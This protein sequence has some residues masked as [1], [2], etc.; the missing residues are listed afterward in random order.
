M[1]QHPPK[2]EHKQKNTNRYGLPDSSV[3][4]LNPSKGDYYCPTCGQWWFSEYTIEWALYQYFSLAGYIPKHGNQRKCEGNI[5]VTHPLNKEEW[6]IEAKGLTPAKNDNISF[7]I[8]L[9]QILQARYKH[10]PNIFYALA[11]P[12]CEPFT[13][14]ANQIDG[15]DRE[16]LHLHWIWVEQF[17]DEN[18]VTHFNVTINCPPGSTCEC[19]KR[20]KSAYVSTLSANPNKVDS[21]KTYVGPAQDFG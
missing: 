4:W 13:Q 21:R 20:I 18:H 7:Q 11:M 2:Y 15:K 10:G 12:R 14:K 19:Q 17:E 16:C 5:R 9:G 6:I 8:G 3:S 1:S